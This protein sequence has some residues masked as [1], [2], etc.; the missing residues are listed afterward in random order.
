MLITLWQST[1]INL[2]PPVNTA[3]HDAGAVSP[4]GLSLFLESRRSPSHGSFDLW[5]ATRPSVADPW[6]IPENLG[7]PINTK[8]YE[9]TPTIS[10]DNLSLYFTSLDSPSGFGP[11]TI[12]VSTRE[13]TD[14]PWNPPRKLGPA[15]NSAR[16]QH[17]GSISG[18]GLELYQ[19]SNRPSL[20]WNSDYD[21]W[22]SRRA[23]RQDDW[24]APVNLG[25]PVNSPYEDMLPFI[26]PE[27]LMLFFTS[28]R[29][30]GCGSRDI[31]VS[32]RSTREAP[33]REP[34]N[35]GPPINTLDWDL[36]A[37][38]STADST[39]YFSSWRPGGLGLL[40]IYKV[41]I[42][43]LSDYTSESNDQLNS[44]K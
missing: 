16:W 17:M 36:W 7:S 30:G 31:W 35:L 23:T 15:I 32:T 9:S 12:C 38:I 44:E 25:P 39:F 5:V 13:T 22:V 26:S 1:P 42:P 18:D 41:S 34:V 10:D 14:A 43:R 19:A 29:P 8:N 6:G 40:D 11:A 37:M 20:D 24:G 3:R 2:G 4:D 21:I 28:E 33:W 27:G